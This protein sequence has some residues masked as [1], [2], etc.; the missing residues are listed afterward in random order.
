MLL[1]FAWPL[2]GYGQALNQQLYEEMYQKK[3]VGASEQEIKSLRCALGQPKT[4][5]ENLDDLSEFMI[6]S[7]IAATEMDRLACVTT[8]INR[9]VA[10]KEVK[11][12]ALS[13][14][15]SHLLSLQ[16]SLDNIELL[17]KWIKSYETVNDGSLRLVTADERVKNDFVIQNLK[18]RLLLYQENIRFLQ[19]HD[20]LLSSPTVFEKVSDLLKKGILGN[21]KT[22]DEVCRDLNSNIDQ[23]LTKDSN[24][25]LQ[26]KQFIQNKLK[27]NYWT[28][29]SE[30]KQKLWSSSGR[31]SM[32][33]KVSTNADLSQSAM[34]RM[35]ARYG[36][37]AVNGEKLKLIMSSAVSGFGIG[38]LARL[39]GPLWAKRTNSAR[40]I[41]LLVTTVQ[42][43]TGGTIIAYEVAQACQEKLKSI[44]SKRT[45]EAIDDTEFKNLFFQQQDSNECLIAG[46]AGTI[47]AG[48]SG[49]GIKGILKGKVP[50]SLEI[51]LEERALATKK[52]NS[53]MEKLEE[54]WRNSDLQKAAAKSTPRLTGSLDGL[55][56]TES[57][58]F[59]AKAYNFSDAQKGMLAK[60]L[61]AGTDLE[62]MN[63]VLAQAASGQF[64]KF[65]EAAWA[66]SKLA[67]A[68]VDGVFQFHGTSEKAVQGIVSS[69]NADG[70]PVMK[71]FGDVGV[72]AV[73]VAHKEMNPLKSFYIA[74]STK[75][76][77]PEASIV[78]QGEAAQLFS[79]PKLPTIGSNVMYRGSATRSPVGN[80]VIDEYSIQSGNLIITKAHVV[81]LEN[82]GTNMIKM[83]GINFLHDS[84]IITSAGLGTVGVVVSVKGEK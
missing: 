60:Q 80:L 77:S 84:L 24:Q 21:R 13:A 7:D 15:C 63:S 66:S 68:K 29:D 69:L 20:P 10:N 62:R 8:A 56:K 51:E 25:H 16:D 48:L 27:S 71:T 79:S 26:S 18:G 43:A 54:K 61:A 81:P 39:A 41:A 65:E 32:T 19:A 5:I 35:E 83:L 9:I 6:F 4:D 36:I 14:T 47:F 67:K 46:A 12:M 74:G 55:S 59:L 23:L 3:C 58:D 22:K 45:C 53:L 38:W 11:Q 42:V 28:I 78:F 52:S 44:S 34:C 82:G 57:F 49:L 76:G 33:S 50:P 64:V 40:E 2:I 1:N 31:S 75:A 70:Q 30:F 17:Q 37:G 73:P 72:Y